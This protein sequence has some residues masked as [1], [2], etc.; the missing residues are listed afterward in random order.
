MAKKKK[1]SLKEESQLLSKK[2]LIAISIVFAL[3]IAVVFTIFSLQSTEVPF[4]LKAA[5]I[6]QLGESDP[7]MLN[8]T[9]VESVTNIL[10]N[11][12]FTVT[13][14]NESLDVNFFR[15]LAKLNY[16]IIILRVHSALR[17]DNSTVDLF[18]SEEYA[19][20]KYQWERQNG[21]V[22]IGQYL[23]AP[24]KYYYAIT[25][26]FIKEIEGR[27]PKSIVI[28]MGCW[29][30]KPKC[31]QMAEAF[32]NKGAKAY[33]GWTDVVTPTHTDVDTL[34]VLQLMLIANKTLEE[35]VSNRSHPY[36]SGNQTVTTQLRFYP[37]EA[38]NLTISD[39]IQEVKSSEKSQIIINSFEPV[40]LFCVTN[41]AYYKSKDFRAELN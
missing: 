2:Q 28:A 4:S 19:S 21:L 7:S 24:E 22:V 12:N 25:P 27:F 33:I 10:I 5:I 30:L 41:I 11:H 15:G 31:E 13:Y 26:S 1:E 38:K 35:A 14:Y 32:I 29:S 18:T 36:K 3:T 23:Y 34:E 20:G 37:Q 6:D 9:F 39:L 16:G 17:E 40:P 8:Y